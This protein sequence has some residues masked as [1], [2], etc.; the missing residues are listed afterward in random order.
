MI[1]LGWAKPYS[2]RALI[3]KT[4]VNAE[5]PSSAPPLPYSFPSMILGTMGLSPSSHPVICGYLS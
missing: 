5:Y 1:T 4:A 2:Y 3:D